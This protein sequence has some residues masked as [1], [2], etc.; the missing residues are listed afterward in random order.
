[1]KIRRKVPAR[2]SSR[3]AAR[4]MALLAG[5]AVATALFVPA[6]NAGPR[7][8]AA[9]IKTGGTLRVLG[10]LGLPFNCNF[11]ALQVS[12]NYVAV[13]WGYVY[14]PLIITNGFYRPGV[15]REYPWLAKSYKWSKDNRTLTFTIRPNVKWSDGQPFTAADVIYT[16]GLIKKTP[17]LDIAGA[18]QHMDSIKQVGADQVVVGV[19]PGHIP[20][21]NAIASNTYIV[22]QHI[23]KSIPDPT[24]FIDRKPIGTGPFTVKSCSS[25]V[26]SYVKNPNYWQPGRPYIDGII[27]PNYVSNETANRDL[28][29]PLGDG[30]VGGNFIPDIAKTYVA[31]DPKH[32]TWWFPPVNNW[33]LAPNT[34]N[35][36]LKDPLVRQAISYAIDR[37]EVA[38]KAEFGYTLTAS[39]TGNIQPFK[40]WYNKA[41][42]AK[43]GFYKH[44]PKKAISLLEQAGMTRGSDGVFRTKAGK[45]LSVSII[46]IGA[47]SDSVA[48][49]QI[50]AEQLK[51]VGFDARSEPLAGNLYSTRVAN[52]D[53]TLAWSQVSGSTSPYYEYRNLLHSANSAPIGKP[54]LSNYQ[55]WIDPATDKL[56]DDYGSTRDLA[57]Q[58]SII[59]KIQEIMVDKVPV[60]PVLQGVVWN[61]WSDKQFVGWA[62]KTNPYINPC[63]YCTQDMG[64]GVVLTRLHLR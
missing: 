43:H 28:S 36:L 44:D 19:K 64:F 42:D 12:L 11:N 31:K 17:A 50:M 32:R 27:Y 60:I 53:F 55:R 9:T 37:A 8:S 56:L 23:W 13:Q 21:F 29:S 5:A 7:E 4:V 58:R 10:T 52:G 63:V 62:T 30:A 59:N 41:A 34:K 16:F 57:K 46:I 47:Y 22:P 54:A 6:S 33:S 3:I 1:M 15:P 18:W 49:A 48:A 38:K 39:Q 51:A 20:G 35:E 2:R 14:E 61:E 25:Q 45:K 40:A 26:M 24:K